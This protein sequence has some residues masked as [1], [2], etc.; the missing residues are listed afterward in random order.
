MVSG[1]QSYPVNYA[2]QGSDITPP[3]VK[4]RN[5]HEEER[6]NNMAKVSE[7]IISNSGTPSY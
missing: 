3:H 1:G 6:R 7:N 5:S 4:M 2:R